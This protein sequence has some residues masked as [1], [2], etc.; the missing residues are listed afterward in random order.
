MWCTARASKNKSRFFAD[1]SQTELRLGSSALR[2]PLSIF[3]GPG[4]K[5][6]RLRKP[7]RSCRLQK[8]KQ[9]GDRGHSRGRRWLVLAASV[10]LLLEK[11]RGIADR[12][13]VVRCGKRCVGSGRLT[14]NGRPEFI[15]G[16][17][18][19][20]KLL[21]PGGACRRK[22]TP[23]QELHHSSGIKRF[24]RCLFRKYVIYITSIAP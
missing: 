16:L 18:G 2:M 20:D 8:R 13:D 3:S 14:S 12:Y 9:C 7:I 19:H 1:R 5:Y 6:T 4:G 17:I 15:D 11:T 23:L 22:Q 10:G 24:S 21:P